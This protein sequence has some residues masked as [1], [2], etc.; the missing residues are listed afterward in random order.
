MR[1]GVN[2]FGSMAAF[3]G[4]RSSG[5][6]GEFLKKWKDAGVFDS[7]LHTRVLPIALWQHKLPRLVPVTDKTKKK[8]VH[9][10]SGTYVC[11]E[12]E[13][14]LEG[15]YFRD[16]DTGA[17]K[18]PPKRCGICKL[19]EWCYQQCVLFEENREENEAAIKAGKPKKVK[20][21]RFTTPMFKFDGD[22]SEESMT[23]HIG[24]VCNLFGK[25]LEGTDAQKKDLADSGI[26]VGGKAGAWR[27]NAY[28]KCNYAMC[29]VNYNRPEDGVQI[30]VETS[31]LGDAVKGVLNKV[32]EEDGR[33]IE[34]DPY[35]IRWKF[36]KNAP[37]NEMYDALPMRKLKLSPRIMKL[38]RGDA[39]EESLDKLTERFNQ[40]LLRTSLEKHCLPELRALVPWDELFPSEEQVKKWAAEDA[41]AEAAAE[42]QAHERSTAHSDAADEDED[43]DADDDEDEDDDADDEDDDVERDE[44]GEELFAC[45]DCDKP[46]KASAKACPHCGKKYEVTDD[47]D[48]E[49]E[50]EDEEEA[51]PK[52]KLPTRAEALAARKAS[53]AAHP[54]G[55]SKGS[56]KESKKKTSKKKKDAAAKDADDDE[57]NRGDAWE[58][59]EDGGSHVNVDNQ[60][61]A[62]P[63]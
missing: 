43:D 36:H 25:A 60:D 6:G 61:A 39:P 32:L 12:D 46:V 57:A 20:G 28:S 33:N 21:I 54:Q 49:E 42:D 58:P 26:V 41:E 9:V 5:G 62:I 1:R 18:H 14:T 30:A 63:F 3:A 29:V 11:H 31:A 13:T 38:I 59:P 37:M 16:K 19:V 55:T 34:D 24:G 7:V 27:E 35:V 40:I 22:V 10:W 17:R 53:E 4:H 48:E 45:D 51:P 47:E 44:D 2:R 8:T 56:G 15:Q 23:L 50:E 52:K